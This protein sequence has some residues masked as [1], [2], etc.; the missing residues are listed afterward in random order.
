[1]WAR[2]QDQAGPDNE[3]IKRR[4]RI[5]AGG[6]RQQKNVDYKE[7]FSS[8]AKMPSCHVVLVHATHKDWEIHQVDVKSAYLYAKLE[9]EVYMKPPIGYLKEVRKARCAGS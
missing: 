4:F 9:E 3:V 7:S 6:H 2:F 5:V 1:V 8:A